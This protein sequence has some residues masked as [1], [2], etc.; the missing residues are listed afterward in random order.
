ME[1]QDEYPV[2]FE[3]FKVRKQ[4]ANEGKDLHD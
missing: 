4:S 1:K 2:R 3:A